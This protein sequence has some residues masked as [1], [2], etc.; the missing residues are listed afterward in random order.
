[1]AII[2]GIS[3]LLMATLAIFVIPAATGGFVLGDAILTALNVTGN[4]GKFIWGIVGWIG[5]LLLDISISLGTYNYYKKKDKKK[6]ALTGGLRLAYSGVLAVAIANLLKV[7]I[8]TPSINIYNSINMFNSLWSW[9]LIVFGLQLIS[10][11]I[12]YN[13]EGGKKWVNILIKSLLIIEGLGYM[14][15]NIGMLL[16]PNPIAFAALLQPF[17]LIPRIFGETFYA[18]WMLLKGGRKKVKSAET[19]TK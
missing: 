15:I 10:L 1:M 2:I 4:F 7:R 5:I 18:I 11:G 3:L 8:S 13:N 19:K 14:I 9:G 12:L 6:A 16:V 17:F